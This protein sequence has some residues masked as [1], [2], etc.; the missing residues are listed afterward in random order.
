MSSQVFSFIYFGVIFIYFF[1]DLILYHNKKLI[2]VLIFSGMFFLAPF[3]F[4]NLYFNHDNSMPLLLI[5]FIFIILYRFYK[6]RYRNYIIPII[7]YFFILPFT[8]RKVTIINNDSKNGLEI[9]SIFTSTLNFKYR[10]GKTV[11]IPIDGGEIINNTSAKFFVETVE[12]RPGIINPLG[13][14]KEVNIIKELEPYSC[15]LFSFQ[16][17]FFFDEPS[18]QISIKREKGESMSDT[19]IQYWLHK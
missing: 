19:I 4:D 8:T 1:L 14:Q 17:N 12:Y 5:A 11:Q 2:S 3:T 7:L 10:S 16:I 18:E 15:N 13:D 9:K 6:G